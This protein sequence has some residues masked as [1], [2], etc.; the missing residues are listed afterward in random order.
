MKIIALICM[1][2]CM[3]FAC[4]SS[5][6]DVALT[7]TKWV[8]ESLEGQKVEMKVANNEIVMQFND[9]EKRVTG[10]AG[11]YRFFGGYEMDG[12][13]LKF[14][15]MGATRMTCPD[16]EAEARFFKILESTDAF[17]LEDEHLSLLQKGKVLALFKKKSV[18]K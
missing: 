16:R 17:Q 9:G 3:L 14:S 13:K 1:A 8:L 11:C 5:R 18:E 15:H 10:M 2:G 4:R 6:S 7:G 12:N